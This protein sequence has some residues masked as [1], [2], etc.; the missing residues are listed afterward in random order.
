MATTEDIARLI[1]EAEAKGFTDAAAKIKLVEGSIDALTASYKRGDITFTQYTAE[2]VKLRDELDRLKNG[3]ATAEA[4]L[5]KFGNTQDAVAA[6]TAKA[7]SGLAGLGQTGLQTGRVIQ[8]FAQGGIGGVL[9]N[10]E[11]FTQAVG[12]GPG[13][14]GALTILG[15]VAFVAGPHLLTL[16]KSLGLITDAAKPA[17]TEVDALK[18]RIE[19]LNKKPLKLAV[20]SIEL[21]AAEKRLKTL[22][23][24]QTAFE[25]FLKRKSSPEKEAGEGAAF[26]LGQAPGGTRK[27]GEDLATRE[28]EQQEQDN[29]ELRNA[30]NEYFAAK[31]EAEQWQ[32]SNAQFAEGRTA[33]ARERMAKAKETAKTILKDIK[34]KATRRIGGLIQGTEAGNDPAA[35]AELAKR[36]R[37]AGQ[38]GLAADIE[39]TTPETVTAAREEEVAEEHAETT[40][41][42]RGDIRRAARQAKERRRA[43][44]RAR[45]AEIDA[46]SKADPEE[47]AEGE[48]LYRQF[49]PTPPLHERIK[50]QNEAIRAS[51]RRLPRRHFATPEG[52]AHQ[53]RTRDE[54]A[55]ASEIYQAGGGAFSPDQARELGKKAVDYTHQGLDA[56]SATQRAMIE[57]MQAM[58]ELQAKTQALIQSAGTIGM[59]FRQMRGNMQPMNDGLLNM[60]P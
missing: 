4:A 11:G 52:R 17:T 46:A 33:A 32:R 57:G 34:D 30:Q 31:A 23:E 37:A 13:A 9:N 6:V 35:R 10:I 3:Y 54:S 43:K 22:Q 49:G 56:V 53:Q 44:G 60:R 41:K 58:G 5:K 1:L 47:T 16:A 26:L 39:A 50:A 2:V 59:G 14:A 36:L 25:E 38:G 28:R 42:E 51:E 29:P 40:R 27:L 21:E 55:A 7:K 19:E 8:D 48:R 12:L 18:N 20:D 15:V 45:E 24:E